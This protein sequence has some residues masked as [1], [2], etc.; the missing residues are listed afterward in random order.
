MMPVS[1]GAQHI[2][3]MMQ[4]PK[5]AFENSG[6]WF[7]VLV[8]LFKL[9]LNWWILTTVSGVLNNVGSGNSLVVQWLGLG[10]VTARAW[11]QSLV[12]ELRSCKLCGVTKTKQQQQNDMM[13]E[14]RLI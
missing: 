1:Q 3:K 8:F 11:V 7:S 14:R 12:R 13:I 6:F 5:L 2:G 4:V 10:T 9:T